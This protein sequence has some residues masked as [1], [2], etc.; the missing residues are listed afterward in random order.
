MAK[1]QHVIE[2]QQFTLPL[3]HELF[4]TADQMEKILERGGTLDYQ[5]KIMASLFYAPSTRTRFSFESAMYRL[6]G[7]VISTEQAHL[8]SSVIGGETLEDTIRVVSNF[9]DVIVLRHTEVGAAKRA[10]LVS[11]VPVINAGDGKGGQHPTQA[12]L[13]L[14]TIY[15]ELGYIDGLKIAFV[16][17]LEQGRTVRSLAY[18][19]GKFERVMLYFIA[20][21]FLQ[22]REDIQNYLTRHNVWFTLENDLSKVI[23][24]VD[25][26]YITRIEKER[27][28]DKADIYDETVKKY[29]IDKDV[30]SKM[31]Q[32]SI[33]MHPLPRLNEIATD[34]DL[35]P[36][37][38]YFKQARNGLLIRMALLTMVL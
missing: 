32:K 38:A 20:P 31:K 15:K 25:V 27:F 4:Q 21:D 29:F 7:K 26:I 36:R 33:I 8:F 23:S 30:I 2:A 14:Y 13:D 24:E 3:I 18:L 17:D 34:V 9:C 37:A 1:L 6:G 35:D 11:S 28:A 19:L 10:S 5:N 22:I 12:L 16:G